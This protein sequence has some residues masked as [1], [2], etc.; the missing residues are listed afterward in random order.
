MTQTQAHTR[1]DIGHLRT[2]H[3][4][5]EPEVGDLD[6][7]VP[8]HQQVG[9][10]EVPVQDRHPGGAR[11]RRSAFRL[12]GRDMCAQMCVLHQADMNEEERRSEDGRN[13]A[14]RRHVWTARGRITA[15]RHQRDDQPCLIYRADKKKTALCCSQRSAGPLGRVD[16]TDGGRDHRVP[17]RSRQSCR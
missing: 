8:G 11:A 3:L 9:R 14:R 10:L 12:D 15:P 13:M 16:N 5:G 4:H 7:E 2:N 17:V 1:A 6:R